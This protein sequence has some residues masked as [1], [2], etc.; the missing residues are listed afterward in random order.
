LRARDGERNAADGAN[1][2]GDVLANLAVAAGYAAGQAGAA[3]FSGVIAQCHAQA[4]ELEFGHVFHRKRSG[5]FP[6]PP[7]PCGQFL[8]RVSIIQ[9][10]HR[11]RV[12]HLPEAFGGLAAHAL[13]GRVGREQIGDLGL[14][15][16]QLVH[17]R[18]VCSV[19][20]LRRVE[21]V[22]EV[23]VAAKF[24]A[25]FLGPARRG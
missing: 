7:V 25:Q 20:N 14:D 24:G 6:H 22:I 8:G 13:G 9:A 15:A 3:V 12:A 11:A 17:Q 19:A 1:I 10:E 5:Q 18:V 2:R 4:V 21:D 16:L 23:L